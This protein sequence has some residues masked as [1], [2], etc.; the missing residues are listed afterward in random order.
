VTLDRAAGNPEDRSRRPGSGRNHAEHRGS[1]EMSSGSSTGTDRR[2]RRPF[3]DPR[4]YN[5]AMITRGIRD[6]VGRDWAAVRDAK[7][8]YWHERISRLGPL[9]AFRVAD[10][11][12]QQ[13]LLQH[14]GWPGPRDRHE[15]ILSHVRLAERLRRV[16]SARNR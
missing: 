10:E 12:R 9:E 4:R 6:F 16:H 7:D 15:D 1:A 13:V 11:L 2:R 3:A 5:E 8:A 14:P